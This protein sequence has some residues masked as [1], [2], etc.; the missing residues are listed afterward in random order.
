M[1]KIA[2]SLTNQDL[3]MKSRK[4]SLTHYSFRDLKGLLAA[5][6]ISLPPC[7]KIKNPGPAANLSAEDQ[8]KIFS[9][10]MADVTPI[11]RENCVERNP[12]PRE[13]EAVRSDPNGNEEKETLAK[14]EDLV[15]HGEGFHVFHTPE[16]IQG[17]GYNIPAEIARRLHQGD[18]SIQAHLDLHGMNASDG[19]ESFE[20]FLK[21][22]VKT[23]KRGVMVIHGRG[24][25]GP[26]G[27]VLKEKVVES[28]T[29]GPWRKWVIAYASAR[30]CDGGAGA[31]YV[32][33]RKRPVTKRGKRPKK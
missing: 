25:S 31:T 30:A 18:F 9:A 7:P 2:P 13:A 21:W 15:R 3:I 26:A 14:L 5:R 11:S 20:R 8:E 23:G 24:L 6:A 12:A 1:I 33:L 28:L 10:A 4:S 17:T 32:L 19:Q 22:A 29:R 16:Y 27:P